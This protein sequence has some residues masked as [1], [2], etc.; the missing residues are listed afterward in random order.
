[1]VA[2]ALGLFDRVVTDADRP[3]VEAAGRALFGP[4]AAALGW[5]RAEGEGERVPTLRALLIGE[6][7]TVGADPGIREEAARRF[8][9]AAPVDPDLE[10]AV[11]RVVAAQ[12]RPGDY[13]AVLDVYR[14]PATPQQEQKYLM[15]LAAFPDAELA[16]RTFDLA[17]EEVR[18][19]N[20][21]FLIGALLANRVGGPAVWERVKAEWSRLL[22]RFP[23]NSHSRM[24]D[25]ARS[26]CGDRELADDVTAFLR[27]HPLATGQRSV[28]QMLERLAVNVACGERWRDRLG[29][30]LGSVGG[31]PT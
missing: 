27:A 29:E 14:H 19:Q 13:E 11:L 16:V 4:R 23:V 8:D 28:T 1:M 24:V 30:V 21:P 6:L 31:A 25:G 22:D 20:A 26:L 9:A 2:G 7:G 18:T 15:T 3:Q 5:E 12:L 17:L 10:G